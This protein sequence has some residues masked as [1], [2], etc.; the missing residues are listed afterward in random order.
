MP[1]EHNRY[2]AACALAVARELQIPDDISKAALESFAGVPGRLELVR[3]V[4]GV[5]VYNDTTATTPEATLAAIAALD[6]KHTIL[7]MGGAD[8]GLDMSALKAV[9]PSLKRVF[10]LQGSGTEAMGIGGAY[11]SLQEAVAGVGR[12][13]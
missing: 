11:S 8:K 3:E 13:R 7:I 4:R 1:G 6:P 9:L 12:A 10:P 5:K 2:N